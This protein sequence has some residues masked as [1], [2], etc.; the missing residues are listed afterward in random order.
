M[1]RTS[2]KRAHIAHT[3]T[4]DRLRAR[5][6]IIKWRFGRQPKVE[7]QRRIVVVNRFKVVARGFSWPKLL[8]A[9]KTRTPLKRPQI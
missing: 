9:I 2:A 7:W 4:R 5:A 8:A 1:E 3:H 6:A